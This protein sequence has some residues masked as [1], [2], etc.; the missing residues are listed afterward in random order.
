ME[1]KILVTGGCGFIGSHLV[2]KL[3]ELGREVVIL[4]NLSKG[5]PENVR[6]LE[7]SSKLKLIEGDLL[8]S[9]RLDEAIGDCGLVFHLAA[10]P[11][12]N[13]GYSDTEVHFQQNIVV[14]RNLLET[15]RKSIRAN[16]ARGSW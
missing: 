3:V 16:G 9:G 14:T 2:E 11:Q 13:I 6:V 1:K 8:D 7:N 15:M 10:N 12:A 5:K 4:D